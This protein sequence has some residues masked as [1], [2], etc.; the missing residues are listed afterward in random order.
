MP[1]VHRL[2]NIV[3]A[4]LVLALLPVLLALR[5]FQAGRTFRSGADDCLAQLC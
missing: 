4:A 1:P 3:A 5:P 2:A